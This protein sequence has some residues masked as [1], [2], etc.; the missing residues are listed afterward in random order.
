MP[1]L[2]AL[3]RWNSA[4]HGYVSPEVFI[5]MAEALGLISELTATI[6]DNSPTGCRQWNHE[7]FNRTVSLNLSALSIRDSSIVDTV[8]DKL[9]A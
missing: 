4:V 8:R 9:I 1:G 5:P 3:A 7:G 6:L 2:E